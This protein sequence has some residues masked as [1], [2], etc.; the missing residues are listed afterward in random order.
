MVTLKLYVVEEVRYTREN[1]YN[2]PVYDKVPVE[3]SETDQ[4]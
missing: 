3:S 4:S 2:W 1:R